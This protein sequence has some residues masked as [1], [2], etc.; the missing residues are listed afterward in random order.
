MLILAVSLIISLFYDDGSK[1][2]SCQK[3]RKA[4]GN[5]PQTAGERC[6]LAVNKI[7]FLSGWLISH[8]YSAPAISNMEIWSLTKIGFKAASALIMRLFC[9]SCR[10]FFLI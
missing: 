4:L 10:P 6:L 8:A 9:L 3:K 7:S 5:L 1:I 2:E